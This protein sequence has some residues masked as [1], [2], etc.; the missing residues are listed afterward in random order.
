MNTLIKRSMK[1]G[2]AALFIGTAVVPVC[3]QKGKLPKTLANTIKPKPSVAGTAGAVV[4]A[5]KMPVGGSAVVA[6]SVTSAAGAASAASVSS[7]SN[8]ALNTAVERSVIQASAS[9][10]IEASQ[11]PVREPIAL[12][13]VPGF[14]SFKTLAI[15]KQFPDLDVYLKRFLGLTQ[16]EISREE[17]D[18]MLDYASVEADRS[19]SEFPK[20]L[21]YADLWKDSEAFIDF[22][23]EYPFVAK[24]F[25]S[26][27]SPLQAIFKWRTEQKLYAQG[28]IAVVPQK[29][30]FRPTGNPVKMSYPDDVLREFFSEAEIEQITRRAE[31]PSILRSYLNLIFQDTDDFYF[32]QFGEDSYVNPEVVS[33]CPDYKDLWLYIAKKYL[34][35]SEIKYLPEEWETVFDRIFK[36]RN[37]QIAQSLTNVSKPIDITTQLTVKEIQFM[38]ERLPQDN[39]LRQ[40][41]ENTLKGHLQK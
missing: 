11:V 20:E 28:K 8:A 6:K 30:T 37:Q 41:L 19:F 22:H 33:Q 35:V 2:L 38:L 14:V 12:T 23:I 29:P 4:R 31:M 9:P 39:P 10:K 3:A 21:N 32:D 17:I 25:M 7:V 15:D 27:E 26:D 18:F 16:W 40:D 24:A 36:V 1:L 34:S 5:P 13:Q